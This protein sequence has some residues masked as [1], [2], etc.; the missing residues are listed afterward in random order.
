[1]FYLDA[2]CRCDIG[3][4]R[5][6]N[7]D[8]FYFDGSILPPKN[9]GTE[10]VLTICRSFSVPACFAVFDG[11]GG[12]KH[13]E[14]AAYLAAQA[15]KEHPSKSSP[16]PGAM[17]L[18]VCL[19]ANKRICDSASRNGGV[20]MGS[21]AAMLYFTES[22]VWL[23]NIGDS[24]IFRMRQGAL[25]QL[26]ID[27]TDRALLER[28]V[29]KIRKPLLTQ[30]LGIWPEEMVIEPYAVQ[31]ALEV[32]DQYLICSDGLTDMVA[33]D[34]IALNLNKEKN[35]GDCIDGLVEQALS[36][37]GRDNITVILCRITG[38]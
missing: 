36:R 33:L 9:N 19:E 23:C 20:R 29:N 4:V 15:L 22:F 3:R 10:G 27:H 32:G 31:S 24:K 21:T 7:E 13:G 1:M 26:S 37:G 17:L 34:E 18:N 11:M 12:E 35:A 16:A 5:T 14:Q 25:S 8:N 2:A 38:C 30:H 28:Q 6:K